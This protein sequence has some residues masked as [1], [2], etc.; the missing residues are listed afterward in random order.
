M[1]AMQLG[2]LRC[3]VIMPSSHQ[4]MFLGSGNF[5]TQR[6]MACTIAQAVADHFAFEQMARVEAQA[7]AAHLA[8]KLADTAAALQARHATTYHLLTCSHAAHRRSQN[9]RTCAH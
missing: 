8:A 5:E 1:A 7:E 6:L 4:L 9:M 2:S 3:V